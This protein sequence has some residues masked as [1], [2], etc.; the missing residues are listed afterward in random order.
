[1]NRKER[2]A[3]RKTHRSAAEATVPASAAADAF[4][5]LLQAARQKEELG[6]H[7]DEVIAAYMKAT[8]ACPTRAE[9]LHGA[10]RFCRNKSLHDRGYEFATQGLAIPYPHNAP[11]VEDWIYEYGLLDELA[12]NAYW[13]GKYAEC[14]GACDRLLNGG[15]LP[16][17]K[18]DRVLKNRNFAVDKLREATVPASAEARADEIPSQEG[19]SASHSPEMAPF[20]AGLFAYPRVLLAILAKQAEKVL[21]FYLLCIDALDYPK[22]SIFLYVR[23]NNNKDRTSEILKEWIARVRDQYAHVELDTSDVPETVEQFDIH[24]W[25]PTRFKVLGRLRQESMQRT[26]QRN[27]DYYFVVDVDNFIKPNTLRDLVSTRLPIVAPL[28]RHVDNENSYSNFHE[29]IDGR[30]Y[31]LKS[32]EYFWLLH[33]RVKGVCKVPV[34]HCTYLVRSDVIPLLSYDD[35]SGRHEYVIFSHSAR[36][37]GVPQYFDNRDVYGYL[38]LKEEAEK[39]MKLIGPQIGGRILADRKS[40]KPRIFGCFGLHS[41]GSTWMFNLVREICRTQGVDFVSLHRDSE[42]NL[43]W[44]VLG[45]RLIVV[46]THNPFTSFQSFIASSDEPAVITVRDPRDAVVSFMQRFSDSSFDEA[47]KAIALSAQTLVALSRLREI[48]VFRYEGGFV[49]SVETLDRIAAL[50]GT[51]PPEGD[52]NAVLASLAPEAVRKTISGLEAAGAIGGDDVWDKDTHWH[53]KHVGD[54]NVGKFKSILSP[55][56][57]REIV[58]QTRE[59]FDCFAYDVTVDTR[60]EEHSSALQ[61]QPTK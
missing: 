30:G 3:V 22:G 23:T 11:A 44:D 36:K 32:E 41:S 10:A 50:L 12:V 55:T 43:P 1:M 42:A 54:G 45:V 14:V 2:R 7:S 61:Q 5:K 52:R 24:E 46:K 34:V 51:S 56:Q 21:P 39:A 4:V 20:P 28:L 57:Q 37:N 33:Q 19:A 59:F 25:N 47:L 8:A 15:K 18:R 35:N 49:G 60:Q 40:D 17:E 9:A 58:K 38:T 31:F 53:A 27:C 48:P 16:A 13:I 6:G 29:K 26:L